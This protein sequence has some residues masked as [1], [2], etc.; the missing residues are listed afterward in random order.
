MGSITFFSI[1][2][3]AKRN[4]H[5]LYTK[6]EKPEDQLLK[7]TYEYH[8]LSPNYCTV[9]RE[10]SQHSFNVNYEKRSLLIFFVQSIKKRT[11]ATI[12][13]SAGQETRLVTVSPIRLACLMK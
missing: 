2:L 7:Y 6:D 1:V 4:V 12:T 11:I 3:Q 5:K 10:S 8:N 9:K 13:P